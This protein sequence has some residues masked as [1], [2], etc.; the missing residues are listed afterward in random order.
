[1]NLSTE[2]RLNLAKVSKG[3]ISFSICRCKEEVYDHSCIII[4]SNI[5]LDYINCSSM[6]LWYRTNLDKY[7]V[8]SVLYIQDI[9]LTAVQCIYMKNQFSTSALPI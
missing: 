9:A 1:M 3:I 6:Y 8:F 4:P 2:Q 5:I 7:L